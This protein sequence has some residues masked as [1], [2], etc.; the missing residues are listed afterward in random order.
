MFTDGT[1]QRR[2]SLL[3]GKGS[4]LMMKKI[5][6]Y[7]DLFF[8]LKKLVQKLLLPGFVLLLVQVSS[9]NKLERFPALNLVP[10]LILILALTLNFAFAFD[11][12][13]STYRARA[14]P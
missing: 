10:A 14:V 4:V 9:K 5:L 12:V 2:G 3:R 6:T 7:R 13:V 11:F 8:C 1:K